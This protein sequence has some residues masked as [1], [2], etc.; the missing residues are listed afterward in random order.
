MKIPGTKFAV[1]GRYDFVKNEFISYD[2][3]NKLMIA[4]IGYTFLERNRVILNFEKL[5][6]DELDEDNNFIEMVF[7]IRF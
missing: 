2:V 6:S 4:G 5:D 7:D 3:K 1:F